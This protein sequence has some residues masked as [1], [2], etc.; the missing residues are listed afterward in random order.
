MVFGSGPFS[1]FVKELETTYT[2][3]LA[4]REDELREK[5]RIER[6][7]EIA[8]AVNRM[9]KEMEVRNTYRV[10]RVQEKMQKEV[11]LAQKAESDAIKKYMA[12]KQ[13]H[14]LTAAELNEKEDRFQKTL[15]EII[16]NCNKN[17]I[18]K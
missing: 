17:L 16:S 11:D 18:H 1:N 10:M 5:F 8:R 13:K 9:K 4:A 6:E 14:N 2:E 3:K 7:V 15:S 12:E